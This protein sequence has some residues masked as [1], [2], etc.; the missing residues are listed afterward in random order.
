MRCWQYAVEKG[1][2]FS[3]ETTPRPTSVEEVW[4]FATPERFAQYQSGGGK[5]DSMLDHYYD[6]LIHITRPNP[7][8]VQNRY[9]VEEAE[10]RVSP[11]VEICLEYGRTGVPPL[12]AIEAKAAVL[13][14]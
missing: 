2:A 10:K 8:V 3:T 9:L 4:A 5:S 13:S 7:A 11:L 6:K 14:A 1:N 12:E